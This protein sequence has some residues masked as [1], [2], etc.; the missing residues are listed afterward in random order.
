MTALP[1]RDVRWSRAVWIVTAAAVVR[2]I[3]AALIPVFPDE[4]YYWDWS[5][6]LAAG[7]FD[8]PPAIALLIRFGSALLTPI[9]LGATPLAI[10]LGTVVAG[11]V[12]AF[13]T[14]ATSR[15]LGGDGAAFRAA[16]VLAVLPL[17]AAGMVLATPDVPMLAGI[18][19]TLYCLVRAFE[20]PPASPSSTRWWTLAGAA[21]GVAFASKYTSI[22]LPVAVLATIVLRRDLRV[23][24]REPGPYIACLVATL[25]F[26]PVLVWN[27]H[28]GWISFVFQ[29]RHGLAAPH[30]SRLL[31]AWRHE[32]DLFGGQAA[33]ASPILFVLLAL[34]AGRALA[35]RASPTRAVL[36][37]ITILS[38]GFFIYSAIRQRVEPN[39]PSP[40][41]IPAVI[42]LAASPLGGI[43]ARWLRAGIGLGALMC[44]AIYAQA[45]APILPIAP[46]KDPIARAFGWAEAAA[47]ADSTARVA[48]ES[49]H[50]RTWL[51]G[52][53][54][55]EA[56]EL[57]LHADGAPTTFATNLAGRVNQYELWP[58]FA[59]V[60]R[61]GDN[62]VLLLDETAGPH[63]A[64]SALTPYFGGVVRGPV[65]ELRRGAGVVATRRLWTLFGWRGGWPAASR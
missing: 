64:V 65:V 5:R 43:A 18:A 29:V 14:I 57:A 4:A 21:L 63:A 41:Y 24:L 60:A 58:G 50:A 56:A 37:A 9:G 33:L 46:S 45:L 25:V 3:F 52:D 7:Y 10:R 13:A 35:R 34:A 12:A 48:S 30:G 2:A 36:G 26:S 8:H 16:L 49:S 19:A 15:R 47:A 39:W 11:W 6:H 62:L 31:A 61:T 55:Q 44:V 17:A 27:A 23:R 22:F 38:F 54:Y 1:A 59:E 51:G 20:S 28:H 40:A 42:L 53:R 32:G